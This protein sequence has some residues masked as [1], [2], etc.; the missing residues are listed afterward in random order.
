MQTP[1]CPSKFPICMYDFLTMGKIIS[2]S[3]CKQKKMAE[4][5]IQNVEIDLF[6]F[7]SFFFA[8][9]F[10]NFLPH[11]VSLVCGIFDWCI[12]E[13]LFFPFFLFFFLFFRSF[14]TLVGDLSEIKDKNYAD[15]KGGR[16]TIIEPKKMSKGT[17]IRE[18]EFTGK[19]LK[20]ILKFLNWIFLVKSIMNSIQFEF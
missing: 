11:C 19:N 1:L 18:I 8:R 15:V 10:S 13:L 12:V 9:K 14:F 17:N 5:E 2:K 6:L 4:S 3:P 16:G 20:Y 7:T